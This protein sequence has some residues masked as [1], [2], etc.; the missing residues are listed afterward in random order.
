MNGKLV[1]VKVFGSSDLKRASDKAKNLKSDVLLAM[2]NDGKTEEAK[3]MQKGL[4]EKYRILAMVFGL[5]ALISAGISVY[6]MI[7]SQYFYVILSIIIALWSFFF[8]IYFYTNERRIELRK[9]K[10]TTEKEAKAQKKIEYS[11]LKNIDPDDQR[12]MLILGIGFGLIALLM[13]LNYTLILDN[14]L[15]TYSGIAIGELMVFA[16]ITDRLMQVKKKPEKYKTTFVKSFYIGQCILFGFL[17]LFAFPLLNGQNLFDAMHLPYINAIN[18]EFNLCMVI[19]AMS[20]IIGILQM[21]RTIQDDG[22]YDKTALIRYLIMLLLPILTMMLYP[23]GGSII[24]EGAIQGG[25][26]ADFNYFNGI[27]IAI[28]ASRYTQFSMVIIVLSALSIIIG[29]ARG[30]SGTATM[31]IGALGMAGVPMIITIMAFIGQVPAP[32]A[33]YDLFGEGFAELIF[34]I[35]YTSVISLALALVGVFYEIVPSA[36]SGNLDD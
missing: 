18:L 25:Q 14:V 36:V 33:F 20:G 34:A 12:M 28:V 23:I 32:Q 35:S 22:D 4:F 3:P 29:K 2:N 5:V 16:M 19:I 9:R 1:K 17:I 31:V 6:F 11:M 21:R 30:Q 10:P 15:I 24:A 13:I 26:L 8:G 7:T 27:Y